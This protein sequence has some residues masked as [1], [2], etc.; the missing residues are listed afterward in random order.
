MWSV[1]EV[2]VRTKAVT[3]PIAQLAVLKSNPRSSLSPLIP[4]YFTFFAG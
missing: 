3:S 2:C 1:R 4:F